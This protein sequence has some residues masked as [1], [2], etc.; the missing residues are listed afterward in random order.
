MSKLENAHTI[1]LPKGGNLEIEYNQK[2]LDTVSK[3]FKLDGPPTDDHIR[4]YVYGAVASAVSKA[5]HGN[6]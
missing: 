5:E 2:F 6:V 4:M 1:P 3:H